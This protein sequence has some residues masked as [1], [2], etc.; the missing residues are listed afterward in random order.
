MIPSGVTILAPTPAKAANILQ[1]K[2][3]IAQ[4]FGNAVVE[5]QESLTT[6]VISPLSKHISI[7]DGPQYPLEGLLL[8]ETGFASIGNEVPIRQMVWTRRLKESPNLLGH[9]RIHVPETNANKLPFSLQL[10]GAAIGI[11]RIRER[12]PVTTGEKFHGFHSTRTCARQAMCN[13]CG[14]EK[15]EG[16]CVQPRRCFNCRGSHESTSVL[17]PSRPCRKNG[18]LVWPTV[19]KLRLIRRTEGKYF[20]DAHHAGNTPENTPSPVGTGDPN[21]IESWLW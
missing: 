12:K 4:H 8:Q 16:S 20:K 19:A 1:Y 2:E 18:A 13:L 14:T 11:Q 17:C 5:R 3:I 7:M 6:F 15:H 21:T 10:S 9:V